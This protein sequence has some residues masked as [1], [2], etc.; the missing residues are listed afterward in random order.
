VATARLFNSREASGTAACPLPRSKR[1]PSRLDDIRAA[2]R[3]ELVNLVPLLQPEPGAYVDV[4]WFT[5]VQAA[6]YPNVSARSL[7]RAVEQGRLK[8]A[9]INA[10]RNVRFHRDDLDADVRAA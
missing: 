10:G 9:R 6:R 8:P 2:L 4:V 3:A 1:P 5:K 7:E